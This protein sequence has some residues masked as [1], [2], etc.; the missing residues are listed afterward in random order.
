M[1]KEKR[2]AASCDFIWKWPSVRVLRVVFAFLICAAAS[3]CSPTAER[4]ATGG[5]GPLQPR[6]VHLVPSN[7]P[8]SSKPRYE[9]FVIFAREGNDTNTMVASAWEFDLEKPEEG[10]IRRARFA[11]SSWSASQLF[12]SQQGTA[13]APEYVRHQ[14]DDEGTSNGYI[15]HLYRIDYHKWDVQQVLETPQ[16]FGLGA[17]EESIFVDTDRGYRVIERRTG[18]IRTLDPS[19]KL[20]FDFGHDLWMVELAKPDKGLSGSF[21]DVKRGQLLD[22]R[23]AIPEDVKKRNFTVRLTP[24]RQRVAFWDL[25]YADDPQWRKPEGFVGQQV[26]TT[27]LIIQDLMSGK[28]RRF[29]FKSVCIPGS[30]VAVLSAGP[31]AEWNEDGTQISCVTLVGDDP[32]SPSEQVILDSATLRVVDRRKPPEPE[33]WTTWEV[34]FLPVHLKSDYDALVGASEEHGRRVALAFLKSH[35]IDVRNMMRYGSDVAFSPDGKRMLIKLQRAEGFYF[36]D[37]EANALRLIRTPPALAHVSLS[38]H[39]VGYPPK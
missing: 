9:K 26:M 28:S 13:P 19:F 25:D 22:G 1:A 23:F 18:T 36:G 8:V 6:E 12:L 34:K 2:K 10:L 29:P 21:F 7:L 32:K 37:L 33:L 31:R 15:V 3:A 24:D 17:N 4:P 14:V 35:G 20:V 5:A 11:P 39:W 27:D 38:I 16:V 30:G